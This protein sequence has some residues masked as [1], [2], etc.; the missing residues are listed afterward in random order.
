MDSS[1]ASRLKESAFELEN[2]LSNVDMEARA[3]VLIYAN[4]QDIEGAL[5]AEEITTALSLHNIK[6]LWH[7][8]LCSALNNEGIKEG[9]EWASITFR[10]LERQRDYVEIC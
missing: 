6:Q 4:K 10:N 9:L 8:Q 5:N 3:L 2:I 7:L 1:D